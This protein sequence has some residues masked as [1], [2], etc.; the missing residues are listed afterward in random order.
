MRWK[1]TKER[2]GVASQSFH[3]LIAFLIIGLAIV[4]SWMS[5]LSPGDNKWF[6]YGWHKQLGVLVLSL[7]VLRLLWRFMN[8]AP[9]L[10]SFMPSWQKIAAHL[11]IL[12]LYIVMFGFPVSGLIMSLLGGHDVDVFGLFTLK[13]F[14]K[15][16]ELSAIAANAREVHG[17]LLWALIIFGSLHVLAAFYHHFVLKD[18]V[19][20]RMLPGV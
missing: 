6:F 18:N 12:V 2:W 20:K 15:T 3:W 5:D 1:N 4:G 14:E 9:D 11:N 13:A 16:P 7:V 10:P 17:M 8:V 19:L